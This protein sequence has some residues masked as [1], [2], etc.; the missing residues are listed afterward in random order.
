MTER[1]QALGA[2]DA[3]TPKPE[4]FCWWVFD[5]LGLVEGDTLIDVFPGSGAV[6]R[7]WQARQ[8][9]PRIAWEAVAAAPDLFQPAPE[10][11]HT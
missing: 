5:L 4:P 1:A 3:M 10:G 11:S 2:G 6:G 7:A 9:Q 8:R